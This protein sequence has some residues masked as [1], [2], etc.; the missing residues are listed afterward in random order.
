MT[1]DYARQFEPALVT[2]AERIAT[3]A[4]RYLEHANACP[5]C[6]A[7]PG[8]LCPYGKQLRLNYYHAFFA[9]GGR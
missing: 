8:Y 3:L 1:D 9:A 4:Y 2:P 5:H 7:N 6:C